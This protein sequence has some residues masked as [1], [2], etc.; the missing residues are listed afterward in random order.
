MKDDPVVTL[1]TVKHGPSM[2]ELFDAAELECSAQVFVEHAYMCVITCDTLQATAELL[3]ALLTAKPMSTFHKLNV[4]AAMTPAD[5][6]KHFKPIF[7]Q[8]NTL[9]EAFKRRAQS[10]QL[11]ATSQVSYINV[12]TVHL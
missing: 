8:A 10:E 1:L 4:H 2:E 5:I 7:E 11:A 9:K 6:Q 12:M 3:Y